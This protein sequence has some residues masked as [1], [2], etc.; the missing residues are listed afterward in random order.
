MADTSKEDE[1][2]LLGDEDVEAFSG[3]QADVEG[4]AENLF[5]SPPR[6][7]PLHFETLSL[8]T[9]VTVPPTPGTT[10]HQRIE[11]KLEKA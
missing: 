5:A 2:N 8:K 4:A 11:F 6:R 1:P 7:Q 10:L 3:S 9:P